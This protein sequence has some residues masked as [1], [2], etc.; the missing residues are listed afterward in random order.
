[1]SIRL[2]T[3][4]AYALWGVA[5]AAVLAAVLYVVLARSGEASNPAGDM[6]PLSDAQPIPINQPRV[7]PTPTPA[8][9]LVSASAGSIVAPPA[10][11]LS[12]GAERQTGTPDE[13]A[14]GLVW[15]AIDL[16]V[17]YDVE[18]NLAGAGYE[19]YGWIDAAASSDLILAIDTPTRVEYRVRACADAAGANCGPWSA[20][21]G[22]TLQPLQA[23][24]ALAATTAHKA[25]DT[26][27]VNLSWTGLGTGERYKV[28]RD[29]G[30][31]WVTAGHS[32]H[33]A[34][35]FA[36]TV[37]SA[38]PITVQYRVSD[39]AADACSPAATVSV[40]LAPLPAGG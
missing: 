22:D 16:A 40:D 19:S 12:V 23:P 34:T 29:A 26:F 24:T 14:V 3:V 2:K 1:M 20:A 31:G 28:E 18:R 6:A 36:D 39:C 27:A 10:P 30:D 21:V 9:S 25:A 32:N 11:T 13:F 7:E 5:A 38:Q 37:Q 35:K 17:R 33:P 15:T 8:D 4:A